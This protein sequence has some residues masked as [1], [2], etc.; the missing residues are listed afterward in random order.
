MHVFS[1]NRGHVQIWVALDPKSIDNNS[2]IA[3]CIQYYAASGF[4]HRF[5]STWLFFTVRKESVMRYA[6]QD[7]WI[8]A[9]LS[10]PFISTRLLSIQIRWY[11]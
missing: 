7:A 8:S 4:P 1:S 3:L 11:E 9:R 6:D 5:S 10:F 2:A